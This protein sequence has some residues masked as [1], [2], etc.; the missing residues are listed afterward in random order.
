MNVTNELERLY[1][2]SHKVHVN[3]VLRDVGFVQIPCS[4][5]GQPVSNGFAVVVPRCRDSFHHAC[6]TEA[7]K[8]QSAA[9]GPEAAF[10]AP[11][12]QDGMQESPDEASSPGSRA[13]KVRMRMGPIN[14]PN[15]KC[16]VSLIGWD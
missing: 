16:R 13:M 1:V 3:A 12:S 7:L 6:F 9:H 8:A 15:P 10:L 4:L 14:C 11:A 5:C 2:P